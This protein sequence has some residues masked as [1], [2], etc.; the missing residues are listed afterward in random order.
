VVEW[1]GTGEDA[2]GGGSNGN[3]CGFTHLAWE[4]VPLR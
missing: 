2:N 1:F 3:F 4:V